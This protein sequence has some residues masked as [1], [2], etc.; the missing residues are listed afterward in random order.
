MGVIF[1]FSTDVGSYKNVGGFLKLFLQLFHLTTAEWDAVVY[2]IRK[3]AHVIEYAIL[4]AL[5]GLA[6][7]PRL[8]QKTTSPLIPPR[9][10]PIL[11]ALL[12]CGVWAA[13]DEY[14]QSFLPSRTGSLRDVGIDLIGALLAQGFLMGRIVFASSFRYRGLQFFGWWFAWGI[15]SSI[16]LLIVWKGGPFS[17]LGRGIFIAGFG[18][19]SGAVG[20]VYHVWHLRRR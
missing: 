7:L 9:F 6:L 18:L 20:V 15:F 10:V 1:L 12:I 3:A 16:M 17:R 19:L 11:G 14:H 5:W 8:T 13:L 4:S 2:A